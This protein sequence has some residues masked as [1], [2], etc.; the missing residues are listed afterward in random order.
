MGGTYDRSGERLA[1]FR[2]GQHV[3][4]VAPALDGCQN[5]RRREVLLG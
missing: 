1:E 3:F 5:I 2:R 4:F